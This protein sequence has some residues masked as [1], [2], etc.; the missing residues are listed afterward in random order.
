[1]LGSLRLR[2][3]YAMGNVLV[4]A[5]G[6]LGFGHIDI[7][8]QVPPGPV[9]GTDKTRTGWS[10]G[11]GLE[12]GLGNGWSV[13]AEYLYYDL[14]DHTYVVDNALIVDADVT[15]HTGKVGV[16]FRF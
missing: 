8:T 2:T 7:S 4:Y 3:G 5:T 1:M 14:G 6:G 10:L 13:K 12:Y 16:N 11:G 9:T 15:V